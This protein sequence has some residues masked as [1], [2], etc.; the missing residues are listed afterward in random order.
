MKPNSIERIS[1]RYGV[2]TALALIL[3]FFFMKLIGLAHV[4]ELRALNLIFLF[5]GVYLS[6]RAY[7][8]GH[9]AHASY[10]NGLGTGMLTS[11]IALAIF[12][13]FVVIYLKVLDPAFMEYLKKDEYFGEYLNPFIAGAAI[14]LEGIMSGLLVSF[15]LMQRYKTSHLK[16]SEESV[17]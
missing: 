5:T 17:L 16:Q 1:V 6:I 11:G 12:S 4:Y 15:I 10:L 9:K 13:T 8:T 7:H 3:F 14:F 2:L